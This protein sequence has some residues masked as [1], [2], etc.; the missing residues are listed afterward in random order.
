MSR[1]PV[2]QPST[3]HQNSLAPLLS[4]P[5]PSS[6]N[7]PSHSGLERSSSPK[8]KLARFTNNF[9]YVSRCFFKLPFC[10]ERSRHAHCIHS[11]AMPN[12]SAEFW[13]SHDHGVSQSDSTPASILWSLFGTARQGTANGLSFG[14]H[15]L[16]PHARRS[17]QYC[18]KQATVIT[19]TWQYCSHIILPRVIQRCRP[20]QPRKTAE[21]NSAESRDSGRLVAFLLHDSTSHRSAPPACPE[22]SCGRSLL[23]I[24][25]TP[26]II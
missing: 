20:P 12:T 14:P 4:S 10:T 24:C 1:K 3:T 15:H 11:F 6:L 7:L 22:A 2:H 25:C 8:R 17:H 21:S 9:R 23:H 5:L 13:V 16:R 19:S 18:S 26:R